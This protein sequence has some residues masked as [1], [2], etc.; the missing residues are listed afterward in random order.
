[1]QLKVEENCPLNG[2]KKCKQFKCAWFVQMKGTSPNDGKEVDEYACAMAWLPLLLVEN[3]MQSRHTGG[4]IE[5][6]RNE[7]VKANESNQNLLELSKVL[8]LKNKRSLS[9]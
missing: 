5:S 9:Q 2:F 1:V 7:M 8:E 3:A 4:A 6:F